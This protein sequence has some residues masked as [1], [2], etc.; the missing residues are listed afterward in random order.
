MLLVVCRMFYFFFESRKN[1]SDPVVIWLTGGPGCSSSLALFY[2]NGPFQIANNLSL[3]WNDFGWDQ[4]SN[5]IYVDQ[6][7]GTGFSY[8]P[9][10]KD[11]RHN[12]HGVSNDLYSFLQEFFK[13]H[14]QYAN[15][16]FY[17]TGESYA[18][19]YIPAFAARVHRVNKA[20]KGIFVNLKGFAIGN[21]LTN[22]E[23][24]YKAY[25]DFALDM[26]L[27]KQ[28]DY[29][30]I[31]KSV[32]L[33]EQDINLCR[34]YHSKFFLLFFDQIHILVHYLHSFTRNL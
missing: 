4:A 18:G 14:P 3:L 29:V 17:I 25:L 32:P 21:G 1:K 20:G 8:S 5:L 22:P 11:I 9:N 28:S 31:S 15:N 16:D 23:I 10:I 27:I 2:E 34:K 7:T 19:H 24:Q 26:K 13:H 12:E 33:C 30:D 6:P